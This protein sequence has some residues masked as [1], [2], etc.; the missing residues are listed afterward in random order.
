MLFESYVFQRKPMRM[1]ID[2]MSLFKGRLDNMIGKES[3]SP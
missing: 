2:S 3:E 1:R